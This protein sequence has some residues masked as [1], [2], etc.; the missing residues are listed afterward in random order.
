MLQS[1]MRKLLLEKCEER[2]RSCGES[3]DD[4]EVILRRNK[5]QRGRQRKRVTSCPD[6]ERL[7]EIHC[8]DSLNIFELRRTREG[9]EQLLIDQSVQGYQTIQGFNSG[10]QTE[11]ESA[12]TDGTSINFLNDSLDMENE[13]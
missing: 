7:K 11:E 2:D 3:L 6:P 5:H 9:K 1:L 4:I 10:Y 8:E 12:I 13:R